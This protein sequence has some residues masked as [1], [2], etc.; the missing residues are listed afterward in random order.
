[1]VPDNPVPYHDVAE[2]T[3]SLRDESGNE[4]G[5]YTT[6]NYGKLVLTLIKGVY[7]YQVTKGFASNISKDGFT[8][9]GIYTSQE[10][11]MNYF[12][13]QPHAILEGLKFV[14]YNA[15][16]RINVVDKPTAGY[17]F[18]WPSQD[19]YIASADFA[20]SYNPE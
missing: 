7:Y 12:P 19:V 4:L 18:L 3:V 1:M 9:A 6:D 11:I 17:V 16:G 10:E 20:P 5:S 15:D 8:I 14:D 13:F 2:A